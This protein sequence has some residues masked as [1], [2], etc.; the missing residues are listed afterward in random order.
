MAKVIATTTNNNNNGFLNT[1]I[2][3]KLLNNTIKPDT[4]MD[5]LAKSGPE[6]MKFLMHFLSS[7]CKKLQKILNTI[8]DIGLEIESDKASEKLFQCAMDS[9]DAKFGSVYFATGQNTKMSVRNS[10]WPTRRS[11]TNT[12]QIFGVKSILKGEI[13]NICNVRSCEGY[14]AA[15]VA[16]YCDF[17]PECI[18]SAPIFGDGMKVTGIIEMINKTS[19]NPYFNAEDV[20]MMNTLASFATLLNAH[21]SSITSASI[22]Q[23]NITSFFNNT[24]AMNHESDMG[25]ILLPK[26]TDLIGVIMRTARDLVNAERCTLFLVDKENQQLWS[27]VAQGSGEI[28]LPM[29]MGIAGHVACTGEV[30]NILDG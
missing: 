11:E 2:Y 20:F 5:Q 26:I 7:R 13:Q 6:G 18:I 10:N 3:I 15:M 29:S 16:G 25:G 24:H 23:G 1:N 22:K 12:D 30:L 14:T 21:N 8:H 27:R 28:R 19:G 9:T 17:E 4:I